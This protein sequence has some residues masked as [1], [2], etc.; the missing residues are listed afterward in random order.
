MENPDLVLQETGSRPTCSR[1]NYVPSG[2]TLRRD[3]I[4]SYMAYNSQTIAFRVFC[5]NKLFSYFLHSYNMVSSLE[6]YLFLK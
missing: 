4:S 2:D 5:C 6:V 3:A 1:L